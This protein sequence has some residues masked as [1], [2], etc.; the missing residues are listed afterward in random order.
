MEETQRSK[1]ISELPP[2]NVVITMG[3]GVECPYLPSERREDWGLEDPT[4]KS[5]EEFMKTIDTIERKILEL[6]ASLQ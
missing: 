3:C 5:D 1:L 4:G 6:K 2:V